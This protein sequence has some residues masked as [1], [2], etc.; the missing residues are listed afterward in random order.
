MVENDTRMV[1]TSHIIFLKKRRNYHISEELRLSSSIKPA[2]NKI[3]KHLI[4]CLINKRETCHLD[5]MLLSR[6]STVAEGSRVKMEDSTSAIKRSL[7]LLG[8]RVEEPDG[9]PTP[10]VGHDMHT[11]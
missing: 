1:P 4:L 5:R 6:L 3:R 11:D 9:A 7:K 2:S 8:L 10:E